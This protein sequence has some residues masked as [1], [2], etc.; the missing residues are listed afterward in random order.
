MIQHKDTKVTKKSGCACGESF[1]S[2]CSSVRY[3]GA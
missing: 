2:L 3:D 1:S